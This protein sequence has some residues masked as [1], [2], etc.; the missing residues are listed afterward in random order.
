MK[1]NDRLKKIEA[2]AK[3]T[4]KEKQAYRLELA[5]VDHRYKTAQERLDTN[6]NCKWVDLSYVEDRQGRRVYIM[7]VGDA[8]VT[9]DDDDVIERHEEI[10]NWKQGPLTIFGPFRSVEEA[11]EWMGQKG[12][13]EEA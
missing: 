1:S 12:A 13:F 2:G 6:D 10:W 9:S 7:E 3:M 4:A 11:E 8:V 5:R